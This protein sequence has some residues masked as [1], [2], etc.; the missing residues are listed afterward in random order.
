MSN[1]LKLLDSMS[2]QLARLED[3]GRRSSPDVA[4]GPVSEVDEPDIH[5]N[6]ST[7]PNYRL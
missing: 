1:Q 6:A 7:A 4:S 3:L 5:L 2:L